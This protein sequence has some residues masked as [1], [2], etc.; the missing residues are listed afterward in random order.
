MPLHPS[1]VHFPIALLVL[2]AVIEIVNCFVKKDTLNR[3]G[4]LLI[5][6]GVIS[7]FVALLTG[8]GAEKFAFQNWGHSLHDQVEMHAFFADVS[9]ILFSIVAV[10]KLV[11]KHTL[12]KWRPKRIKDGLV[13]I[14]IVILCVAGIASLATTGH[15][16]GK[17]VY[18][19]DTTE[20]A[21]S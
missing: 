2:G 14:I 1:I 21:H 8:E 7:G 15:L 13:S 10:I 5:V 20:S 17:I 3:F 18:E 12:F 4:T 16:G 9:I 11:F 19:H 6:I